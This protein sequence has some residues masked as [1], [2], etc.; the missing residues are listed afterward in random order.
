M[1]PL[2]FAL[3]R[4]MMMAAAK[5]TYF[6]TVTGA[7]QATTGQYYGTVD[8][9]PTINGVRCGVGTYEVEEGAI[10][11]LYCGA[12]S[13]QEWGTGTITVDGTQKASVSGDYNNW[14]TTYYASYAHT[15]ISDCTIRGAVSVNTHSK[16]YGNTTMTTA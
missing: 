10:I 14:Q 16:G 3:R 7:F 6:I 11:T 13:I 8:I 5:K 12:Y 2:Q 4:R 9:R 15:V 1:I